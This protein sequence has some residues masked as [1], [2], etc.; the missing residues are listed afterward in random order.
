M[1]GYGALGVEFELSRT[2]IRLEGRDN[3]FGFKSPL[4]FEKSR[5]RS[6]IGLS[7]GLAYHFR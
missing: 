4:P 6:D 5:T 2:A 3:L 1:A 7:L